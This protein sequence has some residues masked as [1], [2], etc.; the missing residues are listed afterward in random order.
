M[1][2]VHLPNLHLLVLRTHITILPL[3]LVPKQN[4]WTLLSSWNLWASIQFFDVNK[5]ASASSSDFPENLSWSVTTSIVVHVVRVSAVLKVLEALGVLEVLWR[6]LG[7][8][9]LVWPLFF[10]ND[11]SILYSYIYY[12]GVS[13]INNMLLLIVEGFLTSALRS[14]MRVWV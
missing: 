13:F 1:S 11:Y 10:S 14:Q 2:F 4:L 7:L 5:C 6:Q 3:L 8:E 9:G 12:S